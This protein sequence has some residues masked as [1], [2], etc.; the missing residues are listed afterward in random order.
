MIVK[1]FPIL[2]PTLP[3]HINGVVIPYL[4]V[5]GIYQFWDNNAWYYQILLTALRKTFAPKPCAF[6]VN[7]CG[8]YLT[9]V[10]VGR[11]IS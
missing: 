8:Q 1:C 10:L 7:T 5:A 6:I 3:A 11:P 9:T 2:P 4:M